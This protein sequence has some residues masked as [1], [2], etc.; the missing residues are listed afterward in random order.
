MIFKPSIVCLTHY[1]PWKTPQYV[2]PSSPSRWVVCK[3]H[4][5]LFPFQFG[6][7]TPHVSLPVPTSCALLPVPPVS[8]WFSSSGA[9]SHYRWGA[10][11]FADFFYFSDLYWELHRLDFM[12][13][14]YAARA[15]WPRFLL[16]GFRDVK[17]GFSIYVCASLSRTSRGNKMETF[18]FYWSLDIG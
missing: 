5:C 16:S 18:V 3:S 6:K 1:Y 10:R 13:T 7:W 17:E 12:L 14:G 8:Q 11:G 4:C 15:W 2:N 9:P